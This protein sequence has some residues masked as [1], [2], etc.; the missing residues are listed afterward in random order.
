MYKLVD[1]DPTIETVLPSDV[2]EKDKEITSLPFLFSGS[3]I[4]HNFRV[5]IGHEED[6][7]AW[8]LLNTTREQ[9]M[10]FLNNNPGFD[11]AQ[12]DLAWKEIY[13]AEGSDWCWWYGD[14]HHTDFFEMFD[15]LFRKHLQNIWEIIGKEP[16]LS[17]MQPI[18]KQSR[19]IGLLEPTDFV[20]PIIERT[21]YSAPWPPSK[22]A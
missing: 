5:W 18:R 10:D 2:F 6:N 17:L 7:L 15:Y 3:W 1:K 11:K 4:D 14:D 20:S 13:I 22:P 12:A 19:Q 9:L 21:D 16:P 8:D